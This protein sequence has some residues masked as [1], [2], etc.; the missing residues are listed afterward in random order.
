MND[1]RL[2]QYSFRSVG[3][4]AEGFCLFVSHFAVN[5]TKLQETADLIKVKQSKGESVKQYLRC[6]NEVVVQIPQPN[7]GMCVEAFIRGIR[8]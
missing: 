1:V 2:V 3:D 4:I 5:K 8:S 7:E 6:F